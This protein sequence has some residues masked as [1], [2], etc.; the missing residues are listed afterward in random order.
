MIISRTNPF[1]I[2]FFK[3]VYGKSYGIALQK[4]QLR[5]TGGARS[6]MFDKPSTCGDTV[7]ETPQPTLQLQ[8]LNLQHDTIDQTVI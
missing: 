7:N 1:G 5:S 3:E 4:G 2:C 6:L 8:K